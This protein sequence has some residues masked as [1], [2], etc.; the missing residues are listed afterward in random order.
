MRTALKDLNLQR[1]DVIHAGEESFS[2]HKKVRAVSMSNL[3]TDLNP[4]S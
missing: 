3:L 1:L 4:I 2:L